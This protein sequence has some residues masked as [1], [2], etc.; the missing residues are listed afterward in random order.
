MARGRAPLPYRT[1]WE[2]YLH[3]PECHAFPGVPCRDRER[4]SPCTR[5]DLLPP[6]WC[7]TFPV[8]SFVRMRRAPDVG[9]V[10]AHVSW[11]RIRVRWRN[12][13]ETEIDLLPKP[14]VERA[15]PDAVTRLGFLSG[16]QP[17]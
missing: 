16:D 6:D 11:N 3:C 12:G 15:Y 2:R 5:R 10:I 9:I 4:G 7:D 13:H 17:V 8:D 14:S 1:Q